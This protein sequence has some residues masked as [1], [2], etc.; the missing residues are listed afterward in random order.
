MITKDD[1]Q[2][3]KE[4]IEEYESGNKS[5]TDG[6]YIVNYYVEVSKSYNKSFG[7]DKECECGHSYYRHFD[8]YEN[9]EACG[10]KYC[11][12]WHFKL[13]QSEKRDEK[14]TKLG[15]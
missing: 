13:T 14:L 4:L 5:N 6:P 1:Y 10:C 3:M 15:I 8:T 9:M 12:C 11:D 2:L 7:D